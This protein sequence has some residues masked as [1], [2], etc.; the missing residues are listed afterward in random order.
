MSQPDQHPA[1]HP[2]KPKD[3]PYTIK[4]DRTVYKV[5][6]EQMTGLQLRQLSNPPIG[7]DRDLFEVV[8]GGSDVKIFDE[9]A[10]QMR[11][12]LRFFTAPAQINP[13]AYK[14]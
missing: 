10:V 6:A 3:H 9:Q 2:D 13:G 8:P 5:D 4:I 12:G 14:E 7:A 1:P 11:D